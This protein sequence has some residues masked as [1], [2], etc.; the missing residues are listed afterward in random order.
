MSFP[1]NVISLYETGPVECIFRQHYGYWKHQDIGT[2]SAEY[3]PMH[4]QLLLGYNPV[5]H[6]SLYMSLFILI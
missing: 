5:A 4:F 1:M 2:Y 3:A 6:S